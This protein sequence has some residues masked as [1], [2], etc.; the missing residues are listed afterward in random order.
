[1][2]RW[3]IIGSWDGDF[4]GWTSG[5]PCGWYNVFVDI[6]EYSSYYSITYTFRWFLGGTGG[7]DSNRYILKNTYQWDWHI[8]FGIYNTNEKNSRYLLGDN[9]LEK[10]PSGKYTEW[11]NTF[12]LNKQYHLNG[13]NEYLYFKFLEAVPKNGKSVPYYS[14]GITNG[15]YKLYNTGNKGLGSCTKETLD[16]YTDSIVMSN[17]G[18]DYIKTVPYYGNS[19]DLTDISVTLNGKTLDNCDYGSGTRYGTS[20]KINGAYFNLQKDSYYTASV[21]RK[22]LRN[23]QWTSST[24]YV[25]VSTAPFINVYMNSSRFTTSGDVPITV[26]WY[27]YT[28]KGSKVNVSICDKVLTNGSGKDVYINGVDGGT[29]S[30]SICPIKYNS[31]V[32]R[33]I[34]KYDGQSNSV[35]IKVNSSYAWTG[36]TDSNSNTAGA[37]VYF[38]PV[39]N[40]YITNNRIYVKNSQGT[41]V[42]SSS[43]VVINNSFTVPIRYNG[44]GIVKGYYVTMQQSN[45]SSVKVVKNVPITNNRSSNFFSNVAINTSSLISTRIYN[46][47]ITP[48][49]IYTNGVIAN[50]SNYKYPY[51]IKY[52]INSNYNIAFKKDTIN[53]MWLGKNMIVNFTMPVD[54]NYKNLTSDLQ[55]TYR[56][57]DLYV[58]VYYSELN[59]YKVNYVTV[60]YTQNPNYFSINTGLTYNCNVSLNLQK[61]NL[62]AN[63]YVVGYM[64]KAVYNTDGTVADF[65]A[66][67]FVNGIDVEKLHY[68]LYSKNSI[69]QMNYYSLY[70][71][72]TIINKL[73]D[74]N[75]NIRKSLNNLM[76]IEYTINFIESDDLK[77]LYLIIYNMLG[78]VSECKFNNSN[79]INTSTVSSLINRLKQLH[80]NC[81]KGEII[82]FENKT[83]FQS[84]LNYIKNNL[85]DKHKSV[86]YNG[87][88][89]N[90]YSYIDSTVLSQLIEGKMITDVSIRNCAKIVLSIL[91]NYTELPV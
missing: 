5:L 16:L 71:D 17:K 4:N 23:S 7:Y 58:Y 70:Y 64:C 66:C 88:L 28:P 22:H 11:S 41:Y 68:S 81:S 67:N 61:I 2:S 21:V 47:Y 18:Y 3:Y 76:N 59:N 75:N 29:R 15:W 27:G 42:A 24:K 63:C 82:D 69:S 31:Y 48:Y 74:N 8:E 51:T 50:G 12:I 19:S 1:M 83:D 37:T 52:L 80:I 49:Y 40:P 78:F 35:K 53:Y 60:R 77:N 45:N 39:N 57:K 55:S 86:S 73:S 65:Y 20:I 14:V 62:P 90:T 72:N 84:F 32:L 46:M 30:V 91:N 38:R 43:N 56:Y 25:F 34:E 33:E 26:S 36:Y 6:N 85:Y 44:Y 79:I 9:V 89:D 13:E 54:A 10:Y 87:F